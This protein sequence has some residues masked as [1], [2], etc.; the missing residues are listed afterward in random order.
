MALS[1]ARDELVLSRA[2]RYGKPTAKPS[3]FWAHL[4]VALQEQ[5]A[6][7]L[8]WAGSAAEAPEAPAPPPT[9]DRVVDIEDV[10]L[11][12]RCP[13]RYEY[14]VALRLGE[15]ADGE[16]YLRFHR[17]VT[18]VVRQMRAD[19]P[20]GA[21]PADEGAALARLAAAWEGG[22]PQGH[23]YEPIWAEA[24]RGLVVSAWQRMQAAPPD[25]PAWRE[26]LHLPLGGAT[27]RMRVDG[28][29][30][31]ADGSVRV[32]RRR[33]G[34][35]RDEDRRAPR[36]ALLRAAARQESGAEVRVDLEYMDT[37]DTVEV[38]AEERYDRPRV[39]KLAAAVEGI[40][41]G[42]FPPAPAEADEVPALPVLDDLPGLR[43]A[44]RPPPT[45]WGLCGCGPL[46]HLQIRAR[47]AITSIR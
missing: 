12:L 32:V 1:R 18:G 11:F 24:A 41:A 8:Q 38:E 46:G 17:V 27:V 43:P 20:A 9:P 34:R 3:P 19:R 47:S 33:L 22:G 40:R 42:V 39:D 15:G 21:L 2:A 36:L 5:R 26:E 35:A 30:R 31:D 25:A 4:E 7:R 14:D 45:P 23:V 28:A 10:E 13:R 29:T 16:G 44:R 37:G 6:P